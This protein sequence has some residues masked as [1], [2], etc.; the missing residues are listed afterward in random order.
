M[1][2]KNSSKTATEKALQQSEPKLQQFRQW[3]GINIKEHPPAWTPQNQRF[4]KHQTDLM[5]NFLVVQN[6]VCLTGSKTLETRDDTATLAAPPS[7]LTFTG[8]SCLYK[9]WLFCAFS[10][11]SIKAIRMGTDGWAD[12]R[13]TDPDDK[14][15][16]TPRNWTT[17]SY[18]GQR[19][20][21]FSNESELF[22]GPL[23]DSL[24]ALKRDG[25]SSR[26]RIDDP[27]EA[28]ALT[29]VGSLKEGTVSRIQI[30]YTYT[31]IFGSTLSCSRVSVIRTDSS[32]VEWSAAK[33]LKVSG[34]APGGK[35]ITGVDV[36]FTMDDNTSY[37]FAGHVDLDE[38]SSTEQTWTLNWLG[39][40]M[41]TSVWTNV[42]LTVPTEN[43][44]K[45]VHARYMEHH[46]GRLYFWGGPEE[47]RL[48]IGGN[49]GN[50]FSVARG[51]GGAWVDIEPGTGTVVHGTA[52]YKTANGA[53][54]VTIM[55]GNDNTGQV[56]RYNLLETN[57]TITNELTTKGYMTEEIS[58]VIGCNSRWG[59]GVYADGLYAVSRYGLG[60]TTM[61]MEYNSQ[62]KVTYVSDPIQCLFTDV[63]GTRL[64]NCRMVYIDEIVYIA[65]A[66]PNGEYLDPLILCYDLNQKAWYTWTI[67]TDEKIL[68]LMS[69][70]SDQH[71]EGLGVVTENSFLLI[72]VTGPK[73]TT[74]PNYDAYIES[75]ELAVRT[76]PNGFHYLA[77]LQYR[78]DYLIGDLNITVY[79]RDY[80]GRWFEVVKHVSEKELRRGVD[81]Y[82]RLDLYVETYHIKIKGKARFRL[83]Q[84]IAKVWQLS[85]KIGMVYG[86]DD[87]SIYEDAHGEHGTENH[88]I[89][90]YNNLRD[91]LLP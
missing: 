20:A 79:G 56:K 30:T 67:P 80:Y 73:E 18:Y 82:M 48:Y 77:Q 41:D 46:D 91:V 58:N 81:A 27:T 66:T 14:A 53:S 35:F 84:V 57:V 88:Y 68:H 89:E 32:P 86:F 11:G 21:C 17:I 65:F 9:D 33:Y 42:S 8:V 70:D 85:N 16:K 22:L 26:P 12:I 83:S 87:S 40:L 61:A 64:N 78:F 39:S 4:D 44:T 10:D 43:T 74:P 62:L 19:L 51:L 90:N 31:N 6:N 63:I 37:A 38:S 13:V 72:P 23:D 3:G 7:G 75:G 50:E 49:P 36:Y 55:C 2:K 59:Y 24:T 71:W 28:A 45:G 25:I 47:Y 34:K 54:I 5:P 15:G 60:V 29:P 69:I 1:A 76:P 52:K